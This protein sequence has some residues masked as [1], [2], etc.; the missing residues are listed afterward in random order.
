VDTFEEE[1]E[2]DIS[3]NLK[4]LAELEPEIKKLEGEMAKYLHDLNIK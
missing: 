3:A 1:E 2:I 4:E